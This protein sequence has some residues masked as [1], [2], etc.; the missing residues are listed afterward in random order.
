MLNVFLTV[1]LLTVWQD[2][3]NHFCNGQPEGFGS[4]AEDFPKAGACCNQTDPASC[5]RDFQQGHEDEDH[6]GACAIVRS[7][8]E[9]CEKVS[10]FATLAPQTQASCLCYNNIG[11]YIPSVWDNAA[12]SCYASGSSAHPVL[13]SILTAS[14]SEALGFCTKFAGPATASATTTGE[15]TATDTGGETTTETEGQTTTAGTVAASTTASNTTTVASSSTSSSSSTATTA[16]SSS[17]TKVSHDLVF[18]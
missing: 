13:Y 10:G 2:C 6:D 11:A 15:A 5:L 3:V 8:L 12:T 7:R 14:S 4:C 9:K 17:G 1:Q 16:K 18:T